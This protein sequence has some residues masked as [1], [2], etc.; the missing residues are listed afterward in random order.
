MDLPHE[1]SPA[2]GRERNKVKS[3]VIDGEAVVVHRVAVVKSALARAA[4]APTILASDPVDASGAEMRTETCMAARAFGR[5]GAGRSLSRRQQDPDL[6]FQ[7]RVSAAHHGT[8]ATGLARGV[9]LFLQDTAGSIPNGRR[10]AALGVFVL[11]LL[12][13]AAVVI[14]RNPPSA[15]ASSTATS[16]GKAPQGLVIEDVDA[17][18]SARNGGEILEVEG[19]LRN[20]SDAAS[21]LPPLRIA[22]A[23]N[24][25]T[26][27]L[28]P[29][30]T[31][32]RILA[33]GA[34]LRFHSAV[35]VPPG[36]QG[37]VSV[38]FAADDSPLKPIGL[39]DT[40]AA[41]AFSGSRK[42]LHP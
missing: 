21:L 1:G 3:H 37:D 36:T 9:S 25:G 40:H 35:A 26:T 10:M 6:L 33:A 41:S 14:V 24:E 11:C 29:V 32:E 38:A 34:A 42:T 13:P 4:S 17:R 12:V 28:R 5:R 19:V 20:V 7:G 27:T 16:V 2:R 31:G 18:I 23:N 39:T 15:F 8:A 30:S 22:L